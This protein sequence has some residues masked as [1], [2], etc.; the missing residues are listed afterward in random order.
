MP[1]L[2]KIVSEKLPV[3]NFWSSSEYRERMMKRYNIILPLFILIFLPSACGKGG[4]VEETVDMKLGDELFHI[5]VVRTKEDQAMGLMYRKK[6]DDTEGMLF[7]YEVDS[8]LSFWMANTEIPLSIAFIDREG[9]IIQIEDMQ[10][11]DLTPVKSKIAVRY[12]LEVNQ[13]KFDE[14]GVAVGDRLEVP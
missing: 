1:A 10:P 3:N 2:P 9:V 4:H 13:G 12:A 7:A 14:L 8:P 11:F 5:E 6:L